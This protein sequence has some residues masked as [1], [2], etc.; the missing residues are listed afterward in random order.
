MRPRLTS[1]SARNSGTSNMLTRRATVA[2]FT[3]TALAWLSGVRT[4]AAEALR[5]G[6]IL[7]VSGPA[8]FLGQD[9][10]DGIQLAVEEI[11]DAG[12]I[13]GRKID[14]VFYDS[15]SQTQQA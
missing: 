13:E 1:V 11:N 12:G 9:M 5:I 3:G 8:A 7:S 14:W 6:T 4:Q 10:K 2:A 15:Q